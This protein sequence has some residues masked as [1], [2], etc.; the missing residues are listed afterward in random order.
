MNIGIDARM[1][2]PRVGGG[3]L[4]RYVEQLIGEL[5]TID[6]Q[7]RYVLFLKKE[8]FEDCHLTNPHFEKRL[9]NVHWYTLREQISL[10]ELMDQEKLDFIHFPHWNVPLNLHTPFVVT[11]H[12]LIMLEQ[13]RSAHATTRHPLVYMLKRAGYR[14]VLKRTLKKA[15]KIIAVSEYTKSSL[16]KHF[17]SLDPNKIDV[18]YEGVMNWEEDSQN[19]TKP[20]LPFQA[21]YFLYVGNAYPHKNLLSL[22]HAFSFFHQ[23]HPEV[24]LVLAGREDI[25]YQRLKQEVEELDLPKDIVHF[26]MSPSDHEL[27]NLYRSAAL[28]FFPSL[29]EG[30]GLPPLEAMQAGVPVAASNTSSLPEI[31]GEAALYFSPYDIEDMVKSM[32]SVFTQKDLRAQLISRGYERVKKFSW[33]KMAL[34]IMHGYANW[35]S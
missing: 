25:F 14:V 9:A 35:I 21:P 12:D 34:A 27:K 15:K 8:N 4:G 13:P 22:L 29:E 28:Y 6:H 11:I 33:N 19:Q 5:Q 1:Y 20:P 30:F 31:L 10:A 7:N 32:E 18:I 17:P 24:H 2:G 16:L 3:G 23:T 26:V